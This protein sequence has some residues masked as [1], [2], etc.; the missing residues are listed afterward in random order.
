[1]P[2]QLAFIPTG[3][4]NMTKY[5]S[6]NEDATYGDIVTASPSYTGWQGVKRIDMS[7]DIDV[8]LF[9]ES[10]SGFT[11][12]RAVDKARN[13]SVNVDFGM[14][15]TP[16]LIWMTTLPNFATPASTLAKSRTFAIVRKI[17]KS[18]STMTEYTQL[19][20]NAVPSALELNLVQGQ[21]VSGRATLVPR[22][23]SAPAEP[24]PLTTPTIPAAGSL[25]LPLWRPVD[26]GSSAIKI[27]TVANPVSAMTIRWNYGWAYD[28]IWGSELLDAATLAYLTVSGTMTIK[29]GLDFLQ[30]AKVESGSL[31]TTKFAATAQLKTAAGLLTFTDM[32]FSRLAE[33][34][35]YGSTNSTDEVYDFNAPTCVLTAA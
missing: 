11:F 6:W 16:L 4:W 26:A 29:Q 35:E 27:A 21:I 17:N 13:F 1:M 23:I 24:S 7:S 9:Y 22:L 25:V 10:G 5:F 34:L 12:Y 15:D 31:Q 20:K 28:K 2:T 18:P 32:T 8:E 19:L 33:S 30:R 14:V 3:P